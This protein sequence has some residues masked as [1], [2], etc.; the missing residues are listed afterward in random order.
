MSDSDYTQN[1]DESEFLERRKSDS[2]RRLDE[3][4]R[5]LDRRRGPGRRL[6]DFVRLAEEGE[7]S[8]EQIMFLH[9]IDA[10][11]QANHVSFPSWTDVLEVVRRL[12]Y[13]KTMA[14]ELSLGG[15][16]ED[17]TEAA[18]APNCVD[19]GHVDSTAR[20]RKAG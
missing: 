12:G 19:H 5:S 11:K 20:Y 1:N 7:M 10:F 4:G 8:R 2:D 9:A 18:D 14:S 6:S 16:V 17:W 13:R 3:N 15:R